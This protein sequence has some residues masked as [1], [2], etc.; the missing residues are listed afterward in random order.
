MVPSS[1]QA[2]C[3][4][5]PVS[6]L[7][8]S[9]YVAQ[10]LGN[11]I[12]IRLSGGLTMQLRIRGLRILVLLA[13]SLVIAVLASRAQAPEQ[14]QRSDYGAIALVLKQELS[15]TGN[16]AIKPVCVRGPL[17]KTP[18]RALLHYLNDSGTR[19]NGPNAC[20]PHEAPPHG[21]EIALNHFT[22]GPGSSLSVTVETGDLTTKPGVHTGELLRLGTYQLE[23]SDDHQWRIVSYTNELPDK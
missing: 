16:R 22:H 13:A 6:H 10:E 12:S 8:R 17:T 1:R 7:P 11:V 2:V 14:L 4:D 9:E 5:W 21:L 3:D 18:P 20:Y 23:Q 15:A 19:V